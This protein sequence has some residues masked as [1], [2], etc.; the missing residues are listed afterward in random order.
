MT[1]ATAISLVRNRAAEIVLCAPALAVDRLRRHRL[2]PGISLCGSS[3]SVTNTRLIRHC[4]EWHFLKNRER[5][6][7]KNGGNLS[8]EAVGQLRACPTGR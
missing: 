7:A 8:I 4:C 1:R 5:I 2:M 6:N 3:Q